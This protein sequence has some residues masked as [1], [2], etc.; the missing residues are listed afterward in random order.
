M[1][2]TLDIEQTAVWYETVLG[3]HRRGQQTDGWCCLARDGVSIMFMTNAHFGPPHA[4]ATQYFSVDD[5]DALWES[6]KDNCK[7]EWGPEDMPYG[8]REFAIKD[9]NGYLLSFG[10]PVS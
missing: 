2:Q 9:P 6:I 4:T 7:A 8:L 5:A 3:F 10:S 1:L